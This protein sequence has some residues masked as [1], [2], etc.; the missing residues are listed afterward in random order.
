MYVRVR[1]YYSWYVT[2]I[3]STN[4]ILHTSDR[5]RYSIYSTITEDP[6]KWAHNWCFSSSF[7]FLESIYFPVSF[8]E[9]N[10]YL[11]QQASTSTHRK[12]YSTVS[13]ST[14]SHGLQLSNNPTYGQKYAV[15]DE[16]EVDKN[17]PINH[18]ISALGSSFQP[19]FPSEEYEFGFCGNPWNW[20]VEQTP[21]IRET[22]ICP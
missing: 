8:E 2:S 6:N 10:I 14:E 3:D 19:Q 9:N 5:S 20:G 12:C 15:G 1:V 18:A 17:R 16:A 21:Q 4:S 11:D 22:R 13:T 7:F